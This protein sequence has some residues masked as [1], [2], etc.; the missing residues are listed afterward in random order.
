MVPNDK[1]KVKCL[2]VFLMIVFA[3]S[4]NKHVDVAA[5]FA[6]SRMFLCP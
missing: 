5:T 2:F 6:V 4:V 1:L 3:L